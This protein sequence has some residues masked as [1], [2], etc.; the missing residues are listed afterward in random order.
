LYSP[1]PIL[2]G[3]MTEECGAFKTNPANSSQISAYCD[4]PADP[5]SLQSRTSLEKPGMASLHDGT[6]DI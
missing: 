4:P 5:P 6:I 3:W 1:K 2:S